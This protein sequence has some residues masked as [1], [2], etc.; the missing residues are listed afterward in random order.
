MTKAV[1]KEKREPHCLENGVKVTGERPENGAYPCRSL[2]SRLPRPAAWHRSSVC[3]F[4]KFHWLTKEPAHHTTTPA[5]L[6]HFYSP[7]KSATKQNVRHKL[8]TRGV[9][10]TGDQVTLYSLKSLDR[11]SSDNCH[12]PGLLGLSL[13]SS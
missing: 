11:L 6:L 8:H 9:T 2:Y 7:R 3:L 13:P 12:L 10:V 5:L 1:L 4:T